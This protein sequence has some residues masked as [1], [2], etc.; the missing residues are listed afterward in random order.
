MK[1][2]L[3]IETLRRRIATQE[4]LTPLRRPTVP[5]GAATIDAALP[6]HGL[7]T[8]AVHE[9][10]PDTAG[11]FTA[12]AGF[13]ACLLA[14]LTQKRPGIVLWVTPG[15]GEAEHGALYPLGLAALGFDPARLVLLHASKTVDILWALEEGLGH[16]RLAAVF[17]I[18]P[19]T[20]RGYDFAASRRLSMR[21][22]RLGVTAFILRSRRDEGESTAAET[23]WSVAA[24]PGDPA[25]DA[26]APRW[27]L[28]LLKSRKGLPGRWDV[29]WDH[30]T[31]SFRLPA[32]VVDRAP[33]WK[34]ITPSSPWAQAS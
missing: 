25:A 8:G 27:R 34:T 13:G 10:Q 16:A 4:R 19:E 6:A 3:D 7:Q 17:G 30:E 12:A 15:H 24:L 11:D 9:V 21:A 14:R 22:A 26:A 1:Q 28:D 5:M 20:A 31:L 33:V 32:P 2:A 18:L 23:R 29:E